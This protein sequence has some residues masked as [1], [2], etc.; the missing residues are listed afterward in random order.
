MNVLI[1]LIKR[2]APKYVFP[3]IRS[4]FWEIIF[5]IN[6]LIN[7]YTARHPVKYEKQADTSASEETTRIL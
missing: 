5:A 6:I 3:K 7:L 1:T 2:I 4:V